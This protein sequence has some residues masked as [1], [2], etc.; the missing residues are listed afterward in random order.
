MIVKTNI[1]SDVLNIV[2]IISEGGKFPAEANY[3]KNQQ[4]QWHLS[5]ESG[6]LK[7]FITDKEIT[8][9]LLSLDSKILLQN[10]GKSRTNEWTATDWLLYI[11]VS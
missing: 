8:Q 5:T 7:R 6:L 10:D 1:S 4:G 3:V 2:W 9:F 11:Y